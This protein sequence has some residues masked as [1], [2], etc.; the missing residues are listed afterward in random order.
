MGCMAEVVYRAKWVLGYRDGGH[1]MLPDGEVVVEG[2]RI[3]HVGPARAHPEGAEIR[4]FPGG[5]LIPGMISSHAHLCS[6]VGDRTMA[7]AGRLDLFNSGFLNYL[8]AGR[9]GRSFLAE[10]DAATGIR[11]AIGDLLKSGVTTVVELGGEVG[12]NTGTMA[13]IAGEM[14]IRAYV[15]PGYASAHY[16]FTG[17]TGRLS[18]RWDEAA[19]IAA[20]EAACEAALANNGR[21]DDRVRGILVPVESVLCTR[22][23]LRRTARAAEE[24]G[25]PVTLHVAETIWEFHET[26]RREQT[27]PLGLLDDCGLLGP[28]VILGHCIFHSGHS[29]TGFP[30]TDDL[31]RVAAGGAHVSHSPA[32]FARRGIKLE[33]FQHYADMGINITLGTDSYPHDMFNEMRLATLMSKVHEHDFRSATAGAMLEAA[34]LNGARALGRDDI[35]R[36]APGAKADLVVVDLGRLAFGPILDPVRALVHIATAA[37]V[38]HVMVDGIVRVDGGRLTMLDE[39]ALLEDVHRAGRRVWDG[40]ADFDFAGR[41]VEAYS[42]P[43]FPDW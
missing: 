20:F 5:I 7:D 41:P 36:L 9:N 26:V 1:R 17:P 34:T 29:L 28:N 18:L 4:A 3:V 6:H 33:S 30:R 39:D 35:G 32:V 13:D 25:L 37:D 15:A 22:D 8:P 12:G 11:F 19:G 21:H 24:T 23:L 38:A 16:E 27:T 14:G 40:F 2:D 31:A 10:D 42:P 43:S